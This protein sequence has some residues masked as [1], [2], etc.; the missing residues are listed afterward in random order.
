MLSRMRTLLERYVHFGVDRNIPNGLTKY[1]CFQIL[2]LFTLG[3]I[4]L[5]MDGTPIVGANGEPIETYNN[6]DLRSYGR[7]WTGLDDP[8]KRGNNDGFSGRVDP[9]NVR[10]SPSC[11]IDI[12]NLCPYIEYIFQ[13]PPSPPGHQRLA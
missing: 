10:P 3:L 1:C 6:F 9:M 2:Q 4:R 5:N 13:I 8:A 12:V 11:A 7:A